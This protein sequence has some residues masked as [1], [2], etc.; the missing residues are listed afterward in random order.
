MYLESKFQKC[1]CIK[2]HK[3]FHQNDCAHRAVCCLRCSPA[4]CTV[5]E[6]CNSH[7]SQAKSKYAVCTKGMVCPLLKEGK[8]IK[9]S[10][11]CFWLF[12]CTWSSL[13]C[14]LSFILGIKK[15]LARGRKT[16]KLQLYVTL[17][18]GYL[19]WVTLHF[20]GLNNTHEAD[21]RPTH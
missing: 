20:T 6:N 21:V 17:F 11:E 4:I 15:N 14:L 18:L 19:V 8:V 5:L 2:V 7:S 1:Q 3:R 16:R 13:F 12:Q 9:V 10:R